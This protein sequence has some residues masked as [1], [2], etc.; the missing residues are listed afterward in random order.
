MNT[1]KNHTQRNLLSL[2]ASIYLFI[3]LTIYPFFMLNGYFN[4]I[5]AKGIFQIYFILITDVIAILFLIIEHKKKE[6]TNTLI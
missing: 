3:T 6:K 1:K 5:Y 2:P 4:A